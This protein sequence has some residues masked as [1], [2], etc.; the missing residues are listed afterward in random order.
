MGTPLPPLSTTEIQQFIT[1]GF[2]VKRNILDP[3][4]CAA[5]RDRLWAGNTSSHL[6]RD[7]PTSW[8]NGLPEA[9]RQSTP[10]GMNDRTDTE[11]QSMMFFQA[12]RDQDKTARYIRFPREPHGFREPR[13]QRTRDVEEIRWI[14]KYVRG[15]EW[16]PWTR[17]SKDSPKVIS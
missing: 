11:P 8:G 10:D 17:P 3:Q 15:I 16:E 7:D 1:D 4:L 13:H 6:R 12:L 9:D 5:A 2:L 14:Q